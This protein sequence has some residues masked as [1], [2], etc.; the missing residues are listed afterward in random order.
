V[1]P[2][3]VFVVP[4]VVTAVLAAVTGL[5]YAR[6]RRG[7][8]RWWAI[9][10]GLAV[11]YYVVFMYTSMLGSQQAD[12]FASIGLVTAALGWVR[13]VGIWSGVRLLV[14]RPIGR[15]TWAAVAVVTLAWLALVTGVFAG[16]PFTPGLIRVSFALWYLLGAVELLLRRPRP[17]VGI[18][19]GGVLLLLGIV[20]LIASQLVVDLAGSLLTNWVLTALFLALGLGVLG[21]LL[22]EERELAAARS[23]QLVLANARL[24]ELDQLKDDFIS[25]VS[26]ELR[27]PLG[28]IKGY[29]GTLLQPELVR[30]EATRQEFLTVIDEETDR[31]TE[32]VGNLLDMSRIEAGTLRV[33][34][35]PTD[36][37]KLLT[38]C[39][40][41]L[42]AREP[43]R[44]SN[45]LLDL[46]EALPFALA[47]PRRITQVVDNLLTNAARYSAADGPIAL[48]AYSV[49]SRV[50]V[51]VV[52]Q[53]RGIPS[54]KHE[55]IFDRFVRLDDQPGGSGLGLAICRGIVEA[56][57]GRIWVESQPGNGCTFTFTLPAA[58][59]VGI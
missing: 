18:F 54:D 58:P 47:D 21:R 15:G 12:V 8:L 52:D 38:E 7:Y 9:V 45:L 33:D 4:A 10:W 57:A 13:V 17:L 36:M 55:H 30:D 46:D 5:S 42:L 40:A 56:H 14:D 6:T 35:H 11:L 53:G 16:Q 27:T 22:E 28:L 44:G 48:R 31:L 39:G 20:G 24:A 23:R 1:S 29:A 50:N 2:A 59:S 34:V 37:R 49:D 3:F 26:H 51:E 41:R 32:L 43:S 19:C 25:M